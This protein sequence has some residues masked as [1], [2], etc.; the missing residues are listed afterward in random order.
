MGENVTP[1]FERP[2]G[3]YA[4]HPRGGHAVKRVEAYAPTVKELEPLLEEVPEHSYSKRGC[5]WCR[6]RMWRS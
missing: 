2:P 5:D 3:F 4:S 1:G 6:A